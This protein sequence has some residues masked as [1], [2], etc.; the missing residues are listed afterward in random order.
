MVGLGVSNRAENIAARL[1]TTEERMHAALDRAGREG[2]VVQLVLVSKGRTVADI[3]AAYGLGIRDFGENRVYEGLEKI[4]LLSDLDGIRWHMIGNIQSRKV[5]DVAPHFQLVHSVDRVKIARRFEVSASEL[6]I[7][8]PILLQ[9]NVSGESSKNGWP[10][11]REHQWPEIW[12]DVQA[13]LEFD[14]VQVRGL[15]TMAPLTDDTEVLRACFRRLRELRDYLDAR[16]PG[17]WPEL[18]MGMSNDFE[19]AIEQGA[20]MLRLGTAVFGPLAD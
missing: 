1:S 16:A 18:S 14:H 7:R 9:C 17:H 3:R 2:E 5:K 13:I 11:W 15:M 12:P 19:I 20:T 10:A 4:R 8:I 6:K